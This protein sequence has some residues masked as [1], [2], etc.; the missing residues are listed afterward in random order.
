[1]GQR[2]WQHLV[3]ECQSQVLD[4]E[5]SNR[6]HLL[7]LLTLLLVCTYYTAREK[8]PTPSDRIGTM[9]LNP[10]LG[11]VSYTS[12]LDN[13]SVGHVHVPMSARDWIGTKRL[14]LFVQRTRSRVVGPQA[15]IRSLTRRLSCRRCANEMPVHYRGKVTF[16]ICDGV[17][18]LLCSSRFPKL[19]ASPWRR[20]GR[21]IPSAFNGSNR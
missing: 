4:I 12:M 14:A 2:Y 6:A 9:K 10:A 1:M 11:K 15:T 18:F 21:R 8:I 19:T 3:A 5:Q 16:E 13:V 7:G 20:I 17:S